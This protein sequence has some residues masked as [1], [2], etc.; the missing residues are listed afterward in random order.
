MDTN[1]IKQQSAQALEQA[2]KEF[3]SSEYPR[4]G[5]AAY[6]ELSQALSNL[7]DTLEAPKTEPRAENAYELKRAARIDRLKRK[8]AYY[9]VEAAKA[10]CRSHDIGRNIPFG[11]PILVG[12]HSERGHRN[13]IKKM[14]RARD[15]AY[16][17]LKAAE[18]AENSADAA[19]SNYAISSDDPRAVEKLKHKLTL[20]EKERDELK[21]IN[22]LVKKNDIAGLKALGLSEQAIHKLFNPQFSYQ[23]KG[24]PAWAITNLGGNIRRVKERIVQLSQTVKE[25]ERLNIEGNGFKVFEDA[26]WNRLCFEFDGKPEEK[27]RSIL[28]QYGFKWSPTRSLWVRQLNDAARYSAKHA[29]KKFEE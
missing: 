19:S 16:N 12:H 9:R 22:K 29:I 14:Q 20:L 2:Q 25:E 27:V 10:D 4:L 3:E 26:E 11:Q 13:A 23:S 28:K 15:K 18:R 24:V 8:A 7:A 17:L 21:Q 6:T 1:Q 5:K